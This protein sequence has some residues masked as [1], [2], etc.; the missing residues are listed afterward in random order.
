[1]KLEWS[2]DECAVGPF[3]LRTRI[4][5]FVIPSTFDIRASS[6]YRIAHTRYSLKPERHFFAAHGPVS[7]SSD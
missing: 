2:N 1:M 4:P 3:F 6:L 7:L 5:S